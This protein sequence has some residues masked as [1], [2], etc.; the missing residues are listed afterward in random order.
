MSTDRDALFALGEQL[1]INDGEAGCAVSDFPSFVYT[2]RQVR[3]A[4]DALRR[5]LILTPE[6]E[7][8]ILEIFRIA[9]NWRE[10]HAYPMR[11]VHWEVASRI[12]KLRLDGI[13]AARLKRMPSI[14]RKLSLIPANLNQIQD[15]AGARA[16]V[17]TIKH[18][19]RL[20]S[21]LT[22]QSRHHYYDEDDY[23]RSPKKGGYRCHHLIVKYVGR[24]SAEVFSGRRIEIQVRTRL[25]HSWATAVEAIG[26][27]KQ[28]D[29]KG[30]HGDPVW[31][32]L[33]DLVAA[34]MALI[35]NCPEPPNAPDHHM[36]VQEIREI[37][38][39]TNAIQTLENLRFA[40]RS[41]DR[42]RVHSNSP[43]YYL[44]VYNYDS[45]EVEVQP[46]F[47]H[48]AGLASYNE[49]EEL[50]NLSGEGKNNSVLVEASKVEELKRAYPNYF[51]DVQVF[52][53]TLKDIIGGR[54]A[55][56]FTMSPLRKSPAPPDE[57]PDH[58]WM[59]PGRH[60]R[61]TEHQPVRS[62]TKRSK[63]TSKS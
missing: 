30:G 5:Q 32:R 43:D 22:S 47:G 39:S 23:I 54:K 17:P 63:T 62:R 20:A 14:R 53:T 3:R 4:G 6:N 28:Q 40:V 37:D 9:N 60:R 2:N 50:D 35:E 44:L 12:A 25:Q 18:V 21:A 46:K 52:T 13:S 24:S 59:R 15:I 49:S 45:G 16:V 8:E 10:S 34:E 11:S 57:P 27:I 48:R 41:V 42:Y 36:R 33:F 31:L 51:G 56:E 7:E 29:M 58:S 55:K 61:W 38:R 1:A 26:L 19:D